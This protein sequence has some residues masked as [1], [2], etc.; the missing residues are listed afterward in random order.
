MSL[1]NL[2]IKVAGK[3]CVVGNS[4][5]VNVR[6]GKS[7]VP[8]PASELKVGYE[9]LYLHE[10]I[11]V[12]LQAVDRILTDQI[13]KYSEGKD[14]LHIRRGD[15]L[16]PKLQYYLWEGLANNGLIDRNPLFTD[17]DLS[18]YRDAA[19]DAIHGMD[20]IKV[21]KEAVRF[22]LQGDVLAPRD[23]TQFKSLGNVHPAYLDIFNSLDK[24]GGFKTH[25]DN[26]VIPR[27][28]VM[29][30]LAKIR[31]DSDPNHSEADAKPEPLSCKMEIEAVVNA[32]LPYI[33]K[34]VCAYPVE[35]ISI[36]K[37]GAKWQ[38]DPADPRLHKGILIGI[39]SPSNITMNEFIDD[40]LH[41][42]ALIFDKLAN[43][44]SHQSG[45]SFITR[46]FGTADA[47]TLLTYGFFMK[48]CEDNHASSAFCSAITDEK[49]KD[50]VS[51]LFKVVSKLQTVRKITDTIRSGFPGMPKPD[52]EKYAEIYSKMGEYV[53]SEV[54]NW[55]KCA[56]AFEQTYLI[57]GR[58]HKHL[59]QA[60]LNLDEATR[61]LR[62][63]GFTI[64]Q[65]YESHRTGKVPE[66]LE[67]FLGKYKKVDES[68]CKS[69]IYQY[70]EPNPR[71]HIIDTV[72]TYNTL[73]TF[74]AKMIGYLR[75]VLPL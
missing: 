71:E 14:H 9:V 53:P 46:H 7:Y 12:R 23:M 27:K 54:K 59:K 11:D 63:T 22:W 66:P 4:S 36:I 6:V 75:S 3:V 70:A 57:C 26:Y 74:K 65:L 5:I 41:L 68:V 19:I 60:K 31:S 69:V 64:P 49:G 48:Y 55:L 45:Q 50:K 15:N 67:A 56:Y 61:K 24:E 43:M 30:H 21:S 62:K 32:L 17:E 16:F 51:K 1:D 52:Y 10:S 37:N 47:N 8:M 58:K 42:E 40:Y 28:I 25:Y 18:K 34:E 20:G 2:L 72:A 13:P 35:E 29:K 44:A 73:T 33:E 39:E 38:Y